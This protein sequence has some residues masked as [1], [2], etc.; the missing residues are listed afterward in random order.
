ME[1]H[2]ISSTVSLYYWADLWST[3]SWT[4]RPDGYTSSFFIPRHWLTDA[5]SGTAAF[6]LLHWSHSLTW[7]LHLT[8]FSFSTPPP[9]SDQSVGKRSTG[10]DMESHCDV[11]LCSLSRQTSCASQSGS[12]ESSPLLAVCLLIYITVCVPRSP[13]L[14][15]LSNIKHFCHQAECVQPRQRQ[16][17]TSNII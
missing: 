13:Q 6:L 10:T 4:L 2:N 3:C 7:A 9:L 11:V 14:C 16:L 1:L 15:H 12:S 17:G 8:L 5:G